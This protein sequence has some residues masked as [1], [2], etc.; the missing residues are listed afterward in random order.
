MLILVSCLP[1]RVLEGNVIASPQNTNG[2][3]SRSVSLFATY[4]KPQWPRVS[5]L[6]VLILTSISLQLVNP[7]IVRSFIDGAR[8]GGSLAE[9]TVTAVFFLGVAV[10]TQALS[11]AVTYLGQS[12][13]WKATNA[14]RLDLVLHCLRLDMGFHKTHT[15]GELIERVDGDV[16]ALTNFFSQL[17][18][19][20]LG[21]GLLALGILTLLFRED[22]RV[23]LVGSGYVLLV[24]LALGRLQ[25]PAV[26]AWSTFYQA[27]AELLGFL[28][29]RLGNTEDICANGGEPYVM[30]RLYRLMRSFLHS[31]RGAKLTGSLVFI[32]GYATDTLVVILT[33]GIGASLFLKG[34]VTIGTVYLMA[35]YVDK[36]YEPLAQIRRQVAD[37]QQAAASVGRVSEL[38]ARSPQLVEAVRSQLPAGALGVAFDDVSFHYD[39]EGIGGNGA[40]NVLEDVSFYVAPGKVLGLLGRTGSGKSTL[41]RLLFRLY[42]PTAGTVSLGGIDAR[43]VGLSDLR[44]RVGMVTQEVQLFEATVRDN[45]TLFSRR[46]QD[47]QILA[48]L[49]ELG[50]GSWVELLPDGLDTKLGAGGEGLS[51]G[52]AQL[53]SFARV[54][55]RNPGLVVLDEASSRLDPATE[56]LLDRAIESL[57]RERTAIIIAHRLGTVQRADEILILEGGRICEAGPRQALASDPSSRFYSLLQTGLEGE[58]A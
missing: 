28:G 31:G 54:F 44:Q 9:L 22:W 19:H 56:Q 49:S 33:L 7:Q 43:D 16:T 13:A 32:A 4:L 39:D 27:R 10:A 46:V 24:A 30:G 14:L 29:E 51:A 11:I 45:L 21:N 2:S 53:L 52:Q 25:K 1:F 36:L 3:L 57:L 18:I 34:R 35:Q 37:L 23:G 38:M 42:D 47:D 41:T 26:K 48:A 5:L 6:A 15:P 8:A 58:S 20:L 12:V 55:L 40:D 17:M 50:L